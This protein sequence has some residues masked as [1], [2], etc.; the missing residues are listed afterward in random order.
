MND[1]L[2]SLRR[3]IK[4]KLA[5]YDIIIVWEGEVFNHYA[6]KRNEVQE[7]ID[8]YPADVTPIVIARY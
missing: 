7:W 6:F 3:F 5:R 1:T 2:S 4:R 8:T